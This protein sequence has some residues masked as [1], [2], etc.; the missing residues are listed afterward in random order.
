M[1]LMKNN[2]KEVK[3]EYKTTIVTEG[4]E[5]SAYIAGVN[6]GAYSLPFVIE[7]KTWASKFWF[8]KFYTRKMELRY[9]EV[10]ALRDECNKV[11][12]YVR[13]QNEAL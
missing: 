1:N 2:F 5:I 6:S 12:E 8:K 13:Q 10:V 7:V 3:I 4:M 11:I 9:T